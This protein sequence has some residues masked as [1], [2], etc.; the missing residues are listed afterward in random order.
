[1]LEEFREFCR[2]D[3]RLGRRTINDGHVPFVERFL[4]ET[5]KPLADIRVSDIRTYLSNLSTDSEAKTYN[6]HLG[7][8]KRFFRDFY[9]R[10]DLVLSFKFAPVNE[11]PITI[12]TKTELQMF[13]NGLDATKYRL[14]FLLYAVT[15]L[16]RNE[17]LTLRLQDIDRTQR[18]ITPNGH[19]GRTKKS[20]VSFYN[21]EAE[22]ILNQ[23]LT[24]SLV[25]SGYL[26]KM[27]E[28]GVR[29]GFKR[30]Q[31]KT[32]ITVRPQILREWFCNQ[33]GRLGVPDRFVDALCGR[34]P[35]SVLARRYSDYSP[36][37]L[38]MV[39]EKANLTVLS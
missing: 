14:A 3:L 26:F 33:L 16:R 15:G 20:W 39:Y 8:L 5:S 1:M 13:Y 32:G 34:L 12:P 30:A 6:N 37:N 36:D 31:E 28:A 38:R 23:Y 25:N 27:S 19:E 35:R 22:M 11:K 29:R 24:E 9:H 18:K 21:S 2:V 17:V 4:R 10:P 7:A